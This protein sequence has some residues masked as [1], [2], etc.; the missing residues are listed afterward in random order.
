MNGCGWTGLVDWA[1]G[2]GSGST[3]AWWSALLPHSKKVPGQTL[4][5]GLPVW[6]LHVLLGF[7]QVL[8][9]PPILQRHA[10]WVN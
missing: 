5:R 2:L 8:Q 1:T 10:C 9:L 3:V 7:L 4:S 6:S